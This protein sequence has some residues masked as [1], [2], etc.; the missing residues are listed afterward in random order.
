VLVFGDVVA[1][2]DPRWIV[3]AALPPGEGALWGDARDAGGDD[4]GG[5][6]SSLSHLRM[7]D[8]PV[9]F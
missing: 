5:E 8:C 7:D 1:A 6:L 4:D 2:L 9:V 3:R